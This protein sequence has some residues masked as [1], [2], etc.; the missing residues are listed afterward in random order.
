MATQENTIFIESGSFAGHGG[1]VLDTQF[2][3]NMG[4]AY[5]LAH[6]LG[7]PVPDATTTVEIP[8]AG[9]Y[10]LW[11]FTKDWVAAW[12]PDMAPGLFRVRINGADS[13]ILGN[14]G[15]QW[16][17]QKGGTFTLAAGTAE[18]ALCDMTGFEGRCAALLLTTDEN[19]TPPN[20]ITELDT[21]RRALC[22]FTEARFGGAYGLVVAGAG[23]AG[24]CAALSAA[25]R[26]VKV[27]L[28]QDRMVIGGNNSSEV[29]VWLG[30]ETKFDPFPKAGD[31]T[32]EFE[33]EK[34]AHY[35]AE[36]TAEIYEDERRLAILQAE[37]NL[38]LY[39][40]YFL[41]D[42]EMDG[43]AV[44]SVTIMDVRSGEHVRLDAALFA[45]CTGDATLG[46]LANADF[47]VTTN[48]HMGMTNIWHVRDTGT[49]Q[50]FPKCPWAIDL[51]NCVF[52]GRGDCVDVYGRSRE[53]S[54][55]C[56]F[57]ESGM[58]HNPISMA[59]YARDTN[60]RAMY[61][62]W[63]CVK[64]TDKDY[65]TY[66][67]G[68][69]AYIG[70]KRESRRLFGDVILTKS[71]VSKGVQFP[72][73]IVPTT[74]NFDVHYPD[75]RFYAAFHE[76]DG[77]IT[78]DYHEAFNKP[79]FVPYRVMYS[80]NIRNL[81]MAGRNVSVSHDA[82][83]TVRVMRTGGVMGEVVGAAAALCL[84]HGTTPR[85]VY[86]NHLDALLNQFR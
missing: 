53:G 75:R 64:N 51:T 84:A 42:A 74:W 83:G 62:A 39:L 8:A 30:G 60:L 31:V 61:G 20:D 49:A 77:F 44:Q 6:G 63:D 12:K 45:D 33:C 41:K 55:G 36:N 35:G 17:W 3:P 65:G 9:T 2:I 79:Y 52:P 80:R 40:G 16:H 78:K 38:D 14:E 21:F 68:F 85:G 76:G 56:W 34:K 29:R 4:S 54:F 26:G 23:F 72:D 66:E 10:T 11:A 82:L 1:W 48:G 18:I 71:E 57:W 67:L 7:K 25:R 70:G 69:A 15:D 24:I 5:L 73:A 43:D 32:A 86:E 28:I 81:F 47:E 46:A 37:E 59:E 13:E 22:S 27:A 50:S 19:L 58:E